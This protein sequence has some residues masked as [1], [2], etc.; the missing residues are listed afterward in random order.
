MNRTSVPRV[1]LDACVLV[2]QLLNDLLLRV[3]AEGCYHPLWSPEVLDE[4][5]RTLVGA[6]AI[7]AERAAARVELMRAALPHASIDDYQGVMDDLHTDRKD[8]HVLAAAIR[9]GSSIIVT[10]NLRHFPVAA[11]EPFGVEARHPDEFL[12]ECLDV[13]PDAVLI[14]VDTIV[15]HNRRP[16]TSRAELFLALDRSNQA[17]EFATRAYQQFVPDL[18]SMV[19]DESEPPPTDPRTPLGAAVLWLALI[20]EQTDD[21]RV[22]SLSVNPEKW[23]DR[24]HW[25]HILND[26]RPS[27]G[28]LPH[29]TRQ[30]ISFVQLFASSGYTVRPVEPVLLPALWLQT[31]RG[32]DGYWRIAHLHTSRPREALRTPVV[33]PTAD[34]Q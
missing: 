33:W 5:R 3:A 24:A 13:D 28:V 32:S 9:G 6:L 10:A 8:R 27:A 15:E 23:K 14:A 11:L 26:W 2:P 19:I 25:A 34:R 30:E 16:P 18:P 17:P 20:I 22:D 7:P 21:P 4:L 29:R 1:L 31:R 12:C